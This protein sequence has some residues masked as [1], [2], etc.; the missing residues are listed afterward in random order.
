MTRPDF[1]II[2]AM[3]CATSSLH[4]Q[5]ACQPN[6]YMSNLKEP[7]F[8]SNDEEYGKGLDSYWS[9]FQD[10]QPTDL[11]GE[12]STHYTKLPT[13]PLTIERLHSVLPDI[14]FIY[15]MRHPVKRLVSQYIHEWSQ[16]II[17][18]DINTAVE[19]YSELTD[20]SR[21]AMQLQP[22]FDVFGAERV[23]PVF[24]EHLFTHKQEE[25]E[26][27]CKFLGYEDSPT[28]QDLDAQ[29]VSSARMR[30]S[31]WRDALVDNPVLQTLRRNL[32]PKSFR[33]WVRELWMMKE[34]PELS[35][36]Q[37]QRLEAIFDKDLAILGEWLGI[38]LSCA[39]YQS[40]VSDHVLD[41]VNIPVIQS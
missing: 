36:Q 39:N 24:F 16:R 33:T 29:N 14:K 2:G 35:P 38:D 34:R 4:E 37:V 30:T 40:Q 13:Y 26:R 8:F 21:Y 11:C 27:I 15:V 32:V 18:V 3:K 12:S 25:L 10:A 5:L 19:Q 22:Y 41:W 20:Y 23:L 17:D 31:A 6:F 1:I 9:H 28:W 7:N